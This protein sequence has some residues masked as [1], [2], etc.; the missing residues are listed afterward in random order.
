VAEDHEVSYSVAVEK[1]S[2]LMLKLI[3]KY[4]RLE[5]SKKNPKNSSRT[6]HARIIALVRSRG[7]ISP[8]ELRAR[9]GCSPM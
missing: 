7:R 5:V 6:L 3:S 8:R 9:L 1:M 4:E 2:C